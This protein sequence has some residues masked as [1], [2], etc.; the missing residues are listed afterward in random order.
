MAKSMPDESWYG[1][2]YCQWNER[3]DTGVLQNLLT[4][5]GLGSQRDSIMRAGQDTLKNQHRNDLLFKGRSGYRL[6]NFDE[7]MEL[8]YDEIEELFEYLLM[9]KLQNSRANLLQENK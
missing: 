9:L 3:Y 5:D 2:P 4:G 8:D 1:N 6:L 7:I